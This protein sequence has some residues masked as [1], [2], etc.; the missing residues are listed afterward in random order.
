MLAAMTT[1]PMID[2]KTHENLQL[3]DNKHMKF[4]IMFSAKGQELIQNKDG[5]KSFYDV[6][7]NKS[8][9][10]YV[11]K[12]LNS[13]P[14]PEVLI[15]GEQFAH[16]RQRAFNTVKGLNDLRKYTDIQVDVI[17]NKLIPVLKKF[18]PDTLIV[19]TSSFIMTKF[20]SELIKNG[21][22]DLVRDFD[23]VR[24]EFNEKLKQ[25]ITGH[26]NIYWLGANSVS[27]KP[28]DDHV[29]LVDGIHKFPLHYDSNKIGY[30][31]EFNFLPPSF[32]YDVQRIYNL[33]CNNEMFS[34]DNICCAD[35]F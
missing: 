33:M 3:F 10:G 18:P 20:D 12:A 13:K 15:L 6:L 28:V 32:Y 19:F 34:S 21:K 26:D 5:P 23:A 27:A 8:L 22:T 29:F 30:I 25:A 16:P 14:R 31:K 11:E 9:L 2:E 4:S 1:E 7:H 35:Y 24:V 17:Q